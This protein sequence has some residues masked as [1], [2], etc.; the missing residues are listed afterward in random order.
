MQWFHAGIRFSLASR[1]SV[2][3]SQAVVGDVK[4]RIEIV[5]KMIG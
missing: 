5:K 2:H 1:T 4:S 3:A